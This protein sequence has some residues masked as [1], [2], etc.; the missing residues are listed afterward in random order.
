VRTVYGDG[1]TR[2]PETFESLPASASFGSSITGEFLAALEDDLRSV[3]PS[4]EETQNCPW[5]IQHAWFWEMLRSTLGEHK[6]TA[7]FFG[8][9]VDDNMYLYGLNP[10]PSGAWVSSCRRT[11]R[12]EQYIDTVDPRQASLIETLFRF[13]ELGV[14]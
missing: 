10:F 6:V 12:L 9:K 8:E 13:R 4:E 1:F 11:P 5:V 3:S 2:I 7:T 14:T